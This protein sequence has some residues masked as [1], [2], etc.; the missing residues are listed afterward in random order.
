MSKEKEKNTVES[1]HDKIMN[2]YHAGNEDN[3]PNYFVEGHFKE[4]KAQIVREV[5]SEKVLSIQP[6]SVP[7]S[8]FILFT[9]KLTFWNDAC[10]ADS[11]LKIYS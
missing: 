3:D 8:I 1:E 9:C 6:N 10:Y 11:S 4:S 5:L 7:V 2:Y